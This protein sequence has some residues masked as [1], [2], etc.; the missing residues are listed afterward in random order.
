MQVEDAVL[1]LQVKVEDWSL[2][3]KLCFPGA[4]TDLGPVLQVRW[5]GA[6]RS[7]RFSSEPCPGDVV[8]EGWR[9]SRGITVNGDRLRGWSRF[10]SSG[11]RGR[12]GRSG[13]GGRG[14]SGGGGSGGRSSSGVR[15]RGGGSSSG[16]GGIRLRSAS[17]V[18]VRKSEDDG[19]QQLLV[20]LDLVEPGDSLLQLL[21]LFSQ[22]GAVD[23]AGWRGEW[24]HG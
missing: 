22:T 18:G 23:T 24:S 16:G 19:V 3:W 17:G 11:L 14:G 7:L 13:G 21:D 2:W 5:S 6:N 20:F 9:S 12:G 4:G 15:R 8:D 10:P 1:V